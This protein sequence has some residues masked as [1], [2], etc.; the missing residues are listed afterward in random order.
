MRG[1]LEEL[2]ICKDEDKTDSFYTYMNQKAR[3]VGIPLSGTFELTPRCNLD[4]KM[5]YVH[6]TENQI[7]KP[8]LTKEQ[9]ISLIDQ[10]CENGMLFATLTGGE[11]LIY[12]DFCEIYEYLQSRGVLVTVLTNGV[13]LDSKMINW[14]IER[15]P[16]RIQVSVYGSTPEAYDKV[17]GHTDA[18]ICV[19]RALEELR[20][21]GLSY[22]IAITVSKNMLDDFDKLYHYCDSKNPNAIRMTTLPLQPRTETGRKFESFA[23]TLDEQ[24]S[25]F[26]SRVDVENCETQSPVQ[27]N[28]P[29]PKG[30]PRVGVNC[31]AGRS[32]FAVT[33]DGRMVPC[34]G[35][36]FTESFPLQ[37]GFAKAWENIH[38]KAVKYIMPVECFDC[39]LYYAC[40]HCPAIHWQ[41][42]GEGHMNSF[43]CEKAEYMITEKYLKI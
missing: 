17:T 34:N 30:L 13:L 20:K 23:L 10:A 41:F 26:R 27:V 40:P 11:C 8:V 25:L 36:E 37:E 28:R 7:Q 2:A 22:N 18:F 33:W 6:L 29:D 32:A 3:I 24:A 42:S 14:F 16:R 21:S 31:V 39:S 43:L 15:P 38:M 35:F 19:D 5:C 4:C 1:L 9:W 12:S